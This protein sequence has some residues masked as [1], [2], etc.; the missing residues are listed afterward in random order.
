MIKDGGIEEIL[1]AGGTLAQM[2]RALIQAALDG[3]GH[4]NVTAVLVRTAGH[5]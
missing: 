1:R 3:G 2:G 5:S 4:D